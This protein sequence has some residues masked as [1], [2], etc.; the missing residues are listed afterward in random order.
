MPSPTRGGAADASDAA[1]NQPIETFNVL[2]LIATARALEL[3]HVY[4]GYCVELPTHRRNASR[5]LGTRGV[6]ATV[7]SLNLGGS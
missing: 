6:P 2:A 4:L 3:P 7:E 1:L 5:R